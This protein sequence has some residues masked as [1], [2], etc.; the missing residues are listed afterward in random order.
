MWREYDKESFDVQYIL[1]NLFLVAAAV[2]E[3]FFHAGICKEFKG[4][5]YEWC[6]CEWEETLPL[7]LATGAIGQQ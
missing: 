3:Y 7:K 1:L 4:V 2:Y 5:F 6:V